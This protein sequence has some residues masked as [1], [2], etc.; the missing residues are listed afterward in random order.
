MLHDNSFYY[1]FDPFVKGIGHKF[2]T[3]CFLRVFI[4]DTENPIEKRQFALKIYEWLGLSDVDI[5]DIVNISQEK[6]LFILQVMEK[7]EKCD[8][9][10]LFKDIIDI[11]SIFIEN[12]RYIIHSLRSQQKY[13]DDYYIEKWGVAYK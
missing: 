11:N 7:Y 12:I 5:D 6:A 4:E 1:N 13:W 3:Q 2:A 10:I 8:L 9:S